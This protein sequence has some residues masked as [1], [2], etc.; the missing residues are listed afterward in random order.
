MVAC[1]GSQ[2]VVAM[3]FYWAASTV[4]WT[5]VC[6]ELKMVGRREMMMAVAKGE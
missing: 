6:S 1:W 5:V 4:Q 2:K 3:V